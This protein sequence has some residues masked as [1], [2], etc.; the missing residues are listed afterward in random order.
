MSQF[1]ARA[2]SHKS[3]ATVALDELLKRRKLLYDR[4]LAQFD[5]WK[6]SA[7]HTDAEDVEFRGL[8]NEIA[9]LTQ[10]TIEYQK[11]WNAKADA[12][13]NTKALWKN[14][15]KLLT[16]KKRREFKVQFRELDESRNT[17]F[18]PA[19]IKA[20]DQYETLLVALEAYVRDHQAPKVN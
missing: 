14:F 4:F 16:P 15:S 6:V 20:A 5:L 1:H 18:L 11:S 8:H 12:I 10:R 3:D 7:P 2:N 17:E 13:L 9:A 19:L